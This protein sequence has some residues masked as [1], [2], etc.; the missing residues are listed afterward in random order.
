MQLYCIPYLNS[1]QMLKTISNTKKTKLSR[2]AI[3]DL[4]LI[5][6]ELKRKTPNSEYLNNK[7]NG[8][9]YK[10]SIK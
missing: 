6:A 9:K 8:T 10:F 1:I 2:T 5:K 7:L 4:I 3:I